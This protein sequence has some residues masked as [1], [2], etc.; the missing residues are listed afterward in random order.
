MDFSLSEEQQMLHNTIREFT[1]RECPP[2]LMRELDAQGKFP[3]DI[4]NKLAS[5]G[6]C[7]LTIP[8][9]YGGA[10]NKI[11]DAAIVIE[12]LSRCNASLGMVYI[13]SAFYGGHNVY[14][15]G[16][17]EQRKAYLP[18]IARGEMLFAY[19]LTEPDAGADIAAV[20]SRAVLKGDSFVVNGVK[21]F[22]TSANES[23]ITT[24]L[25]RT[26]GTPPS[27]EGLTMFFIDSKSPG[28]KLR[29][30][31]KLGWKPIHTFE[32][33]YED[34]TVPK[35]NIVG[36]EENLGKGWETLL[37]T[38]ETERL[39]LAACAV[40]TAQG[41][42]DRAIAYAKERHQFG[43][44]I[45]RF[46]SIRH[47]IADMLT[48]VTA[49]RWLT[50]YAAWLAEQEKPC[51]LECNMAKLFASDMCRAVCLGAMDVTGAYGYSTE[52]DVEMFLRDGIPFVML[53]GSSQILKNMIARQ[54]GGL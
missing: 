4:F 6:V 3:R 8:E 26:N 50:Y 32:V 23:D 7:G 54:G 20:S 48:Q 52:L 46:Q 49:G 14:L 28:I 45:G 10:G 40:G 37:S 2:E 18:R 22:I 39:Q 51:L 16:N 24:T 25:L 27:R 12:E 31:G 42:L 17:E 15:T 29:S 5:L 44:P 21:T 47:I 30:I 9:R 41:A 1:E 53:G 19:A 34:V 13:L 11:V 38:L 36:G 43:Q 33:V 35:A